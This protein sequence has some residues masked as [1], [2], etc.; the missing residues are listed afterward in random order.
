MFATEQSLPPGATLRAYWKVSVSQPGRKW[1]DGT[2]DPKGMAKGATLT[3]CYTSDDASKPVYGDQFRLDDSTIGETPGP[4]TGPDRKNGL[5][6]AQQ[7]LHNVLAAIA[8]NVAEL[9]R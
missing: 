6:P 8:A 4:Y 2:S 5:T 7:D 3:L 9:R 1:D